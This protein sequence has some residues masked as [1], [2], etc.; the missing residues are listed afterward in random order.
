[1]SRK[2][3]GFYEAAAVAG[4]LL[5]IF[6]GM[7]ASFDIAVYGDRHYRFYEKEYKKYQVTEALEMKLE[8]VMDVTEHMMAYLRGQE[9]TLSVITTVEG[10]EQDFF[11]EQDRFHM[12]EVRDLFL[13]GLKWMRITFIIGM[14]LVIVIGWRTERKYGLVSKAVLKAL[15]WFAAAVVM[16]GVFCAVNFTKVFEIFHE[17]FFDNDLWLFDPATDYMIRMLPEGFFFDMVLRI[18]GCFG[19]LFLL[20]L[21]GTIVR[22]CFFRRSMKMNKVHL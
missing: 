8:D 12:K 15:G 10:I 3:K 11:N 13:G 22:R 19:I 1:M 20:M 17:I 21:L 7:L 5:I 2:K 18:G 16:I 6:S 14:I 9:E 4:A